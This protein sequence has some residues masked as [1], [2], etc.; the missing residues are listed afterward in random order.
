[1]NYLGGLSPGVWD[2]IWKSHVDEWLSGAS[3]A[4]I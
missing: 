1:M 2:I 3:E 4:D